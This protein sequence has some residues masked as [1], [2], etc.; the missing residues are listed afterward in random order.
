MPAA[1]VEDHVVAVLSCST[2]DDNVIG[3][4]LERSAQDAERYLVGNR[5]SA[6]PLSRWRTLVIPLA[7]S[8]NIPREV[9]FSMQD[10]T[11][12][13]RK[14]R[15]LGGSQW[16]IQASGATWQR[17]RCGIVVLPYTFHALNNQ[18]FLLSLLTVP[19][20]PHELMQGDLGALAVDP[21]ST[22]IPIIDPPQFVLIGSFAILLLTHP[23]SEHA[24]H[25]HR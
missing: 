4:V 16:D 11:I 10:L 18:G 23:S 25:V 15:Q 9:L 22:F 24:I 3:L 1:S 13:H 19:D 5:R 6:S 2:D 7:A 21:N 8:S 14:S 17:P 12:V 20:R